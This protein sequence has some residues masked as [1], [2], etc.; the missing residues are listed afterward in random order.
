MKIPARL[1]RV[2]GRVRPIIPAIAVF[3]NDL[4]MRSEIVGAQEELLAGREQNVSIFQQATECDVGRVVKRRAVRP[5]MGVILGQKN[6]AVAKPECF[7]VALR[8]DIWALRRKA[9]PEVFG[10]AN[11][12]V[13]G[14]PSGVSVA[15]DSGSRC[16]RG[17]RSD[18]LTAVKTSVWS[19]GSPC[20]Q[21]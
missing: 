3:Y 1:I 18:K 10:L 8:V 13:G 7:I 11:C 16:R 19:H 21:F 9:K 6:L 5:T 20:F 15:N 12:C 14:A 17:G 2:L 4:A